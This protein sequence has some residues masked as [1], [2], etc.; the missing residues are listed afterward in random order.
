MPLA[1]FIEP[2]LGMPAWG[3]KQGYGSFLAFEFGPPKLEVVE[4]LSPEK[5]LRRSAYVHGQW[6]LSTN[7]CHWR[8]PEHDLLLASSEDDDQVIRR[9]TTTLNAQKLIG[10]RVTPDDGRSTFTFDLGG[11]LETW[12]HGDDP[13]D[14]Q[15]TVLTDTESF[16]YR[17]DGLYSYR[18]S[19]Q[20]RDLERWLP[21][22]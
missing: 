15:W 2:M 16:T 19:T 21:L 13:T 22:R 5:G 4:R 3:V 8:V 7:C 10:V 20:S 1:T 14:E 17:A 12:P 9:A 11:T 18:P 6:H